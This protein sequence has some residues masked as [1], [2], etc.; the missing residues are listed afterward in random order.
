MFAI[1]SCMFWKIIS[2]PITLKKKFI[3]RF[4]K[5]GHILAVWVIIRNLKF[6]C[7]KELWTKHSRFE[8]RIQDLNKMRM[9][10]SSI[11]INI[12][13][14]RDKIKYYPAFKMFSSGRSSSSWG[15]LKQWNPYKYVDDGW[16]EVVGKFSA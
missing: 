15:A 9:L 3:R 2:I 16:S 6:W 14:H 1:R 12:N 4:K 13:L 10:F 11:Y 8:P 5:I 7:N